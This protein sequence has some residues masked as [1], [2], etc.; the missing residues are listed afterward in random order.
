MNTTENCE[1]ITV[2]ISINAPATK[3]FE[4]IADPQH[5]IK[6]WGSPGRFQVTEMESDLRVGGA[7]VMRGTAQGPKTFSIR[8]E[9]RVVEPPTVL[10]FTWQPDYHQAGPATIVRFEL[11]ESDGVTTVHL[12]HYGFT[13]E[14]PRE[15]YRGW[16]WLMSLLEKYVEAD[17]T[18]VQ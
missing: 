17:G 14:V 2:D 4:A 1:P 13:A 3:V 7:Y 9:Y 8:G 18:R 11:A 15:Q 10:E 6:W 16:P 5:R 12:K